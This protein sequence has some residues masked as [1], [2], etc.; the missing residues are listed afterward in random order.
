MTNKHTITFLLL[1]VTLCISLF[2]LTA[3]KESTITTYKL[4]A[5]ESYDGRIYEV[6]DELYG[7]EIKDS[8][9]KIKLNKKDETVELT[10]S[11]AF[12]GWNPLMEDKYITFEGSYTETDEA[13]IVLIPEIGTDSIPALKTGDYF[14]LKV[15]SDTSI[16]FKK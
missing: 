9:A 5:Y 16:I 3:C 7:V 8:L 15:S 11:L 14:S 4:Y 10:L 13:I 6:G 1:F 12:M 2:S